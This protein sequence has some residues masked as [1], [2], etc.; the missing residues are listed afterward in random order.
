MKRFTL[1]ELLVVIAI[2]G[3]LATLL[4]PSLQKA[5]EAGYYTV[6]SSNMK[7]IGVATA[8]YVGEN[9]S[10]YMTNWKDDNWAADGRSG[11]VSS[12]SW[13]YKLS[14]YLG[15]SP[16]GT[17]QYIEENPEVVQCPTEPEKYTDKRTYCSYQFTFRGGNTTKHPG[18]VGSFNEHAQNIAKISFPGET[19]ALVEK[20]NSSSGA[21]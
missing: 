17:G 21:Q 7:Q 13:H 16:N 19:V 9:D 8:I 20:L 12:S 10:Y 4:M 2:I 14:S 11:A 6:C 15:L 3:I 18:V 1:I 5:R